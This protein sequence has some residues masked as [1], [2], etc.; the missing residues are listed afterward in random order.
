MTQNVK[1][2]K[3]KFFDKYKHRT[4]NTDNIHETDIKITQRVHIHQL[5]RTLLWCGIVQ[6]TKQTFNVQTIIFLQKK[7]SLFINY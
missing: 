3:Y 2:L 5:M 7:Q 1:N 6:R 4:Q